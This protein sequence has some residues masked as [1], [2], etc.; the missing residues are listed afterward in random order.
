MGLDTKKTV[1]SALSGLPQLCGQEII[2]GAD[3]SLEFWSRE[4]SNHLVVRRK[5]LGLSNVPT[6]PQ[7]GI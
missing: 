5:R 2:E 6:V 1:H 7:I 3:A 4:S